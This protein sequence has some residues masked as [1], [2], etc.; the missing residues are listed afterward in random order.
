[1]G[2]IIRLLLSTLIIILLTVI[3]VKHFKS[4]QECKS[5]PPELPAPRKKL[6]TDSEYTQMEDMGMKNDDSPEKSS[7]QSPSTTEGYAVITKMEVNEMNNDE[8]SSVPVPLTT[9]VT[10]GI[11]KVEVLGMKND[12]SLEK[13]SVANPQTVYAVIKTV[14]YQEELQTKL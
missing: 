10:A 11:E 2:N 9:E 3:V 4:N 6:A 1:M 13:S 14:N 7:V 12:D 8:K 5:H